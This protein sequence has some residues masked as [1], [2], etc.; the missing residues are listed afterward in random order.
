MRFGCCVNMVTLTQNVS[1]TDVVPILK[2]LGYDYA[3]LSLSHLCAMSDSKFDEVK[4]ILSDTGLPFEVCNNFF[5]AGIQLTGPTVDRD[6]ITRY[7]DKAFRLCG[8]LG[9]QIIV[10]GSGTARQ[11]PAGFPLEK[12]VD[13]LADLLRLINLYAQEPGITIAIEPLRKQECNIINTYMDA[14][15]LAKLVNAPQIKCLLDYYHL[16]EENENISVIQTDKRSLSHIHFSEPYGRVFPTRENKLQYLT[17]FSNLKQAGYNQRIS[18]EAY[19]NHFAADA[20]HALQ[21]LKEIESGL[22]INTNQ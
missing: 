13:Q 3:E 7:L 21:L 17:F 5:P 9:I 1:G 12:A 11:V 10:F 18:I 4:S 14:L 6:R 16:I 2:S 19:S 22:N 15:G 20:R 8:I